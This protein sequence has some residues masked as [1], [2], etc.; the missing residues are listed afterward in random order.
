MTK[1]PMRILKLDSWESESST[2]DDKSLLNYIN[3]W[4]HSK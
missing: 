4:I 1:Y 3:G 2:V